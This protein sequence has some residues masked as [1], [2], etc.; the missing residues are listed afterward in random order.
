MFLCEDERL[1][2]RVAV[3][4]LHAHSP[5]D[6][7]QRFAREARLGAALNHPNLVSVF[8]T[9]T[10]DEAVLIVMEYVEGETL[11]EALKRGP[12]G[13]ERTTAVVKDTASALDHAH[14]QHVVHRD[15]KPANILLRQDGS[16]K[17][18]DLG[19]A[20]A[21]DITRITQSGMVLGTAAYMAPEQL[22]GRRAGPE[23]DVYALAT[24]AYECLCGCRARPG[25]TPMEIAH[26]VATQPPPDLSDDWPEAPPRAAEVLRRAMSHE[27]EERPT[28][29]GELA[30]ELEAAFAEA[31]GEPEA[32]PEPAAP[33]PPPVATAPTPT[34]APAPTPVPAARKPRAPR[35]RRRGNRALA[36]VAAAVALLTA[37]AVVALGT[38]L[39]GG[40]DD[41]GRDDRQAAE[42]RRGSPERPGGD[43]GDA[44]QGG[45]GG[46]G[47][48][49]SGTP[50]GSAPGTPSAPA[51][52]AP[53]GGTNPAE[54]RRLNS[55]G[56]RMMKAGRNA[57]AVPVLQRAVAAFPPGSNDIHHAY[58]LYNLGRA[59]RLTG[60]PREAIPVL[61]RRLRWPNQRETVEN[62]L[63]LARRAAG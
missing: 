13:P 32:A 43:R 31:G 1:G 22:E 30:A 6:V 51:P 29:A 54:G 53:A 56:F 3:K 27:P 60:R 61:E 8:D 21:A 14:A 24:V 58:A 37:A 57:E 45:E 7:A 55:Q 4:R 41:A 47:A 2:R 10:D 23:V 46:Q 28:S 19:I 15:V 40:S 63:E 38:L 49:S 12:L 18:V 9:T 42:E 20:T 50:A 59:L 26:R 5:D 62:E 36:P 25:K 35:P 44:A 34:P 16:T 17:V 33:V 48:P 39:S 52:A 11:R